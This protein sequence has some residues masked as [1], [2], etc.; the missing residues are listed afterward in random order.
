[1]LRTGRVSMATRS[2]VL[3]PTRLCIPVC[4]APVDRRCHGTDRH[5]HGT[6]RHCHG[7]DKHCHGTDRHCHG[8]DKLTQLISR[9]IANLC[10]MAPVSELTTEEAPLIDRS[11][12][13]PAEP[14]Y[15]PDIRR[16][17]LRTVNYPPHPDLLRFP[18]EP[19]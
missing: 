17:H 3:G 14:L 10:I 18:A 12:A 1:M 19:E 4:C 9:S 5:C 2:C 11:T 13:R 16:R 15:L 7:T 8:T 6:D